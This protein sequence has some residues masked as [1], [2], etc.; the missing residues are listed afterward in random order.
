VLISPVSSDRMCGNGSKL[1][2]GRF[3]L[4]FRKLFFIKRVV[5]HWNKLATEVVNA[6]SL[7]VFKS[8]LDNDLNKML[9]LLVSLKVVRQLD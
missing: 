9:Q 5:K 6:Q 8:H 2:W 7:S 3:R 1:R 4:D